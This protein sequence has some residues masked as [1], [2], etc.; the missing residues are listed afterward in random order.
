MKIQ[1]DLLAQFP[2][3]I[4]IDVLNGNNNKSRVE[5]IKI[6]YDFIPKYC[7]NCKLQGHVEAKCRILHPE[8]RR[9]VDNSMDMASRNQESLKQQ[10]RM[11]H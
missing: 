9:P 1:V 2:K 6:Q 8:L 11:V 7:K 3:Y 10:I 5:R 4:E